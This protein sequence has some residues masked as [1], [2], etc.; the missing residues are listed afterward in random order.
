MEGPKEYPMSEDLDAGSR[1][2]SHLQFN[3]EMSAGTLAERVTAARAQRAMSLSALQ[4]VTGLSAR[5]LRDIESANPARRYGAATLARIDAAFGWP[6]GTAHE[7]WT[8]EDPTRQAVD[9]V[10]DAIAAQ[11]A[12]LDERLARI[13]ESPPW[14]HELVDAV[15]LLQPED[16]ARVLDY[17]R[18]LGEGP[19]WR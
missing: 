13:E 16:R 6:A 8:S 17:A 7:V 2:Q 4:R 11:M 5:T 3:G 1:L 12:A 19:T 10:R 15:R 14:Q 18:R 9:E